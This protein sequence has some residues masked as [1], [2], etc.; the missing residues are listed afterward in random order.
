MRIRLPKSTVS[1]RAFVN[2]ALLRF[3]RLGCAT[4]IFVPLE[5]LC[6]FLFGKFVFEKLFSLVERHRLDWVT[7]EKADSVHNFLLSHYDFQ[8]D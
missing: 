2:Y 6:D 4:P 1:S 5:D 7:A 3:G 8:L